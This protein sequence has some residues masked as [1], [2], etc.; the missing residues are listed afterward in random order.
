MATSPEKISA[1][2]SN[3]EA[4]QVVERIIVF[5]AN[6]LRMDEFKSGGGANVHHSHEDV[7]IATF[8]GRLQSAVKQHDVHVVHVQFPRPFNVLQH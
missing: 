3:E 7:R 1:G 4:V 5:F 2:G 8:I 6:G